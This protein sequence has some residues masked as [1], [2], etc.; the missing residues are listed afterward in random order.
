MLRFL[1]KL[2]CLWLFFLLISSSTI[3]TAAV[4]PPKTNLE[5]L[6]T[7]LDSTLNQLIQQSAL[8]YDDTVI[9]M[10]TAADTAFVAFQ[11]VWLRGRLLN[12]Y[13]NG[14]VINRAKDSVFTGKQIHFRWLD[15][16]VRYTP[17]ERKFWQKQR[18][19]R[20]LLSDFFVEVLNCANDRL[21]YSQRFLYQQQDRVGIDEI[22]S[23]EQSGF[24]FTAGI[25]EQVNKGR[26]NRLESIFLLA[27]SGTILYVFYAIRSR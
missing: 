21:I 7:V 19:Q 4:N 24:G 8:S 2:Q 20:N 16:Q 1:R 18:L 25:F 17:V 3:S 12:N 14:V 5:W 6:T 23:I 26:H 13:R 11:L 10:V 9:V 15:W 22:K 27:I